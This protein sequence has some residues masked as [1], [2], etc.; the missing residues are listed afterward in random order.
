MKAD[1]MVLI[2]LVISTVFKC[3][4]SKIRSRDG[5]VMTALASNQCGQGLIPTQCH[6]WVEFVVG[7][8]LAPRVFSGFSGF[9][10]FPPSTKTNPPNSNST[11]IEDLHENHPRLMWLPL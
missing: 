2:V 11:R 9:S 1:H 3:G 6:N 10:G 8:R 5:T 7:S 4:I